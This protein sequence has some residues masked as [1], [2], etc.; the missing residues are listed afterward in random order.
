MNR[1]IFIIAA[2][3]LTRFSVNGQYLYNQLEKRYSVYEIKADIDQL[4]KDLKR[5]HFNLNLYISKT[6]LEHEFDSLKSAIA[7]SLTTV[8]VYNKLLPVLSRIGDGHLRID[9]VDVAKVTPGDYLKY[10]KPYSSPFERIKLN[11]I[12]DRAYVTENFENITAGSEILSINHIN[13]STIISE[14]LQRVFSDGY[15][16]TFKY[17]FLNNGMLDGIWQRLKRTDT[18]KIITSWEGTIDSAYVIGKPFDIK[19]ALEENKKTE[20]APSWQRLLSFKKIDT[21]L[22]YIKVNT[23]QTIMSKEDLEIF[24]NELP[25]FDHVVLDL[26]GNTGGNIF[27]MAHLLKLFLTK[28][29]KLASFPNELIKGV[30]LPTLDTNKRKQ[31]D[32]VKAYNR[33]GYEMLVPFANGYKGKLYILVNGGTFSAAAAFANALAVTKRGILVGEETGGGRNTFNAGF[34]LEKTSKNIGLK[35]AIGLIPFNLPEPSDTI[36]HGV[37]PDIKI[38]YSLKDYLDKKDLEIDWVKNHIAN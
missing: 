27:I 22:A 2:F 10:G 6:A 33:N 36:G 30:L 24:N 9:Y 28:P 25:R 12:E 37:M 23:F 11:F 26:R 4:Y 38:K 7:D 5:H 20:T 18:L 13:T 14:Y 1:T 17:F 8:Q 29:I 31:L 15:N 34:Y 35:Y 21:N 3:L 16:T 19:M 32:Y